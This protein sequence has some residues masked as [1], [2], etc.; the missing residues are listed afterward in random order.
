LT[1]AADDGHAVSVGE[2]DRPGYWRLGDADHLGLAADGAAQ[3][4]A[5]DPAAG[6]VVRA[7]K[8]F[9]AGGVEHAAIKRSRRPDDKWK[10]TP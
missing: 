6:Q 2:A 7:E 10:S 9:E 5:P 8:R 3:P 4:V 1:G